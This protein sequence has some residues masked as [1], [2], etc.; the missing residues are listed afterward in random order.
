M[1]FLLVFERCINWI[2]NLLSENIL[3]TEFNFNISK[4]NKTI[5]I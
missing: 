3:E 1:Y 4:N 5:E 2:S